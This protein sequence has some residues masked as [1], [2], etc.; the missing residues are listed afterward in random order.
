MKK[1]RA[2]IIAA[3]ALLSG[4]AVYAQGGADALPFVRTDFGPSLTGTAGAGVASTELGVWGAFR[5][6]A[7]M[8]FPG[9]RQGIAGEFRTSA[10]NPG[11]SGA[12][13][14][15]LMDKLG[16]G[17]GVSYLGGD[18]FGGYRA[19]DILLSSG[20][21]YSITENLAVGVNARIARQYLTE[22]VSYKGSGIDVNVLAKVA[23]ALTATA[24]LS[25]VG[26]SV[27]SSSGTK[28][29]QPANAYAGI[30]Y[31]I[32]MDSNK[33]ALDAMAEYYFSGNFGA[34]LGAA[35]TYDE[36][37]TLRAGYRY[38][39][40]WCVLPSHIAVGVEGRFQ[41]FSVNASFAKLPS[42]NIICVGAGFSF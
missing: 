26:N 10:G 7:S 30:E 16:I 4:T 19:H 14:A 22:S 24:G 20:F 1:M 15:K 36:M 9:S 29:K 28:Y 41:A 3:V 18:E 12:G 27:V 11:F 32:G 23:Y 37:V 38:A 33:L 31:V 8:A 25:A 42:S 5:G 13:M 39:T 6:A 2:I 35:F 40:E 17:V 21:A 34:A